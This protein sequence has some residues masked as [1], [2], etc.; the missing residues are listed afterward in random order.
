ML[1]TTV[2]P[3]NL[4]SEP[5]FST[6]L[7]FNMLLWNIIYVPDTFGT[8]DCPR[9]EDCGRMVQEWQAVPSTALAWYP[10]GEARWAPEWG[11]DLENF[12]V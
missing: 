7:F 9:A 10:L 8:G 3:Q 11:A 1:I 6:I 12:Y 2:S 5:L 4:C